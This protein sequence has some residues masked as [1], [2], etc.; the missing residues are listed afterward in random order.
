MDVATI[1]MSKEQARSKLVEY[2]R[3]LDR[4]RDGEW[5]RAYIAY[6]QLAKGTPLVILSEAIANAPRDAQGRPRLAIS[7]AD[8]TQTKYGR[9]IGDTTE[10][11]MRWTG[12]WSTPGRAPHDSVISVPL[13]PSAPRPSAYIEGYA[14]VPVVPPDVQRGHDLSNHFILWEVEQWADRP[15]GTQPDRDPYLLRRIADD[16]YAIVAAWDL[17]EVERAITA[18]RRTR[19]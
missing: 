15:I 1:T 10:R 14:L 2:R 12:Q 13:S 6:K 16:F 9:S 4:R 19:S 17:T 5:E 18:A 7:R 8:F 11:F 3:G